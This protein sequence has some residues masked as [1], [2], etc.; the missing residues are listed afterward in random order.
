[1][2]NC[3]E[4]LALKALHCLPA[5]TAHN[6]ALHSLKLAARAGIIAP[7]I[8]HKEAYSFAGLHYANRL[9]LAAGFDK[10]GDAIDALA[11]CGFGFI[12]LGTVTPRAQL[13]NAMP[14]L[15]RVKEKQAIINRMGFNNKGVDYLVNKVRESQSS[16]I[17]GVNIGKNKDTPLNQAI[18][19]Y[20]YCHKAV[21]PVADYIVINISSPNTPDL[22]ELQFGKQ[23][24]SLLSGLARQRDKLASR[25]QKH[26]PM[27]IKI[28][29]DMQDKDMKYLTQAVV[30]CGFDGV[31]ATNTTIDKSSIAGHRFANE[32]GGLSGLPLR[33]LSLARVTRLRQ[34]LPESCLLIGVGGISSARDAQLFRA[35]GADLIQIYTGFIYQG[36]SLVKEI[37]RSL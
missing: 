26:V 37:V 36:T 21:Y 11:A 31:V 29:P 27:L 16:I 19:D 30:E 9:G 14:R 8:N 32:V 7:E 6:F 20:L 25:Q 10:S 28:A 15:F 4:Y 5:E 24:Q 33:D 35:A 23:L 22:R 18:D 2:K 3:M 17:K 34:M 12:E 1:M 13:G